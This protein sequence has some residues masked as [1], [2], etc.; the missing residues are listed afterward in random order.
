VRPK[1]AVRPGSAGRTAL[2]LVVAAFLVY[3]L[4]G[5][6]RVVGSDEVTMLELSRAMLRGGIVVPEGSTIPGPDGRLYTKN[7]AGQAVLALPLIAL[8]ETGSAVL[9]L[10]PG[11]RALAVRFGASFFNALVTALLLGVFYAGA[12]ALGAGPGAALAGAVLLGFTTPT[13]I[14][15][16]SFMAEPLQS[17]GLLLALLAASLQPAA[18]PRAR[19][20]LGLL[21]GLG[22]LIAVSAKLTMLPLALVCLAPLAGAPLRAWVGPVLGLSLALVGHALYGW[23]RFGTPFETGYG[24]QASPSAFTT[25]ALVGLYGLLLSS[26]KGVAWFA[27]ALW[28][29]PRG[30][31]TATRRTT[32]LRAAVPGRNRARR[33][34]MTPGGRAAWGTLALWAVGLAMYCRFQHWAGD[35]SFG[36]RYLVSLLP[37][38]FLLVAFALHRA[39]RALR[40]AAL[41]LGVAGLLVTL[42]GVGVYF[43]AQMR[44]A[45]DYPYTLPLEDPRFMSDSHFNPRY[46]PIAGHWTM[47][48]RNLSEHLRG[49]LPRISGTIAPDARLGLGPRDQAALLHG[50]DF[51][52]L[53]AL[54]AG[55]PARPVLAAVLLL[56]GLAGLALGWLLAAWRAEARAG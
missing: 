32:A 31:W 4:T 6:G 30:W 51:W 19:G 17:L 33:S 18:V 39:A 44:E 38:A 40:R 54:Y 23:A 20:R 56:A 16:K 12:R 53:Y 27:P 5:G 8:S 46:S 35:G 14:Y 22:A 11:K 42:G 47:L 3:A 45:G 55:T 15:A 49:V 41:V 9:G 25:P 50:L 2:A 26:G 36:P 21:A 52:W 48:V 34:E 1:S 37:P 13:W 43:G 28:L 24:A 7:T 29:A 10:G